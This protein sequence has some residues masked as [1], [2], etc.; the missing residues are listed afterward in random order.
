MNIKFRLIILNF[1]QFFVWGSYLTSLGGYMYG[2]LHFQ[3]EQIGLIFMTMGIASIIMPTILGIIADRWVNAER[4]LGLAHIVG[5]AA[6]YWTST[7]TD[8]IK[9]FW[10]MLLVSCC[11]MPTIALNNTVSYDV[12]HKKG[13]NPQKTFP[14]IRVWG[15]V[16]F[17]CAMWSV[18]L[19]HWT[20]SHKQLLFA[21]GAALV[22][23][24]YSFTVP[25]CPPAATQ[26][27][28]SWASAMGLDAFVL[29]RRKQM[30][31]FFLFAMFL[32]A[33]LQ[34]TNQ[35][36]VPFLDHF[37][38]TDEYKNTFG[39]KYPN[40]LI[41]ISQISE[42][43]FILTIPFFLGRFGIKKVMLMSITAW[44]LRF[45]LFGIG[46]PGGGLI[47]LVLSMIVYGMAFDFFNISGSLFVEREADKKIRASAQ[48]LFML[49]TNGVGAIIGSFVSGW[50]IQ[51][52]TDHNGTD[53]KTVWLLFALYALALAVIF[54]FIFKYK[55]EAITTDEM[56]KGEAFEMT[57]H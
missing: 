10:A 11:Y 20:L 21:S 44:V 56:E 45:G 24:L 38:F 52:H 14:P 39:V 30:L 46:D 47:L 7:L 19:L 17:I 42:T 48:G 23:G 41:S 37:K 15:T 5:A 53:W 18:D 32:G 2:T 31:I 13:L 54:P 8:P 6:L 22:M 4:V 28:K 49:M 40:I 25:S 43:L 35:W 16:G 1:M 51:S 29:F 26:V 27:K 3:G 50:V 55:H 33:A 12:L 57:P 9:M 36:G 34:I